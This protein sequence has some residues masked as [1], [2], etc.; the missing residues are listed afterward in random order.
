MRFLFDL[1]PVILFFVAYELGGI[2]WATATAMAASVLQIVGLLALRQR[3]D[4]TAWIGFAVITLFGG[5]TLWTKQYGLFGI[6]P[7]VFI[8][9][10]PTVLYW[11]FSA[12]LFLA[13]VVLGKNPLK[14]LLARGELQLPEA[15]WRRLNTVWASFFAGLGVLNLYVAFNYPEELWVKF[16]VF[17]LMVLMVIFVL[18]QGIFLVRH[19]EP[20]HGKS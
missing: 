19:M 1:I 13:P 3:V 10:K 9:W 15:V 17:G 5:L 14:A 4:A 2:Y 20:P 16:K 7:T 11:I 6:E 12:I 8:R 18:G